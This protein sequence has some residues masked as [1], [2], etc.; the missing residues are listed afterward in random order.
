MYIVR[1]YMTNE[2]VAMCSRKED[3]LAMIQN[4]SGNDPILIVEEV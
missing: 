1:D 2:T 3:A 4:R